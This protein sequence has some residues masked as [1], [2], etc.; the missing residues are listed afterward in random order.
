MARAHL[1]T[2]P[3]GV[4]KT[5]LLLSLLETLPGRKGG[6]YT[7]EIRDRGQRIGF[8]V[9]DLAGREGVLAHVRY[10]GPPRVGRYGVDL[11]TFEAI[12]VQAIARALHD[13]DLIVIDEIGSMELYSP[14][15]QRV[16][17]AILEGPR[18]LLATILAKPHPIADR[19]KAQPDARLQRLT[20]A[21]R[22]EVGQA[23][24]ADLTRLLTR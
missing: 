23:I 9:T 10:P 11:E 12:G 2:G 4:G 13:A 22:R 6:F 8:Q 16:L 18:P 3:P 1:I 24:T 17:F 20:P 5:S 21:N 19:I 7:R 14:A 15:F